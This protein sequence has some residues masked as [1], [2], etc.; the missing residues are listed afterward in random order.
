M[1][2]GLW[3]VFERTQH[4][5][6]EFVAWLKAAITVNQIPPRELVDD[7]IAMAEGVAAS[8]LPVVLPLRLFGVASWRYTQGIYRFDTTLRAELTATEIDLDT[9]SSVLDYLPEQTLWIEH[10]PADAQ[11]PMIGSF[12]TVVRN[13]TEVEQAES[14]LVVTSFRPSETST[15]VVPLGATIGEALRNTGD[16]TILRGDSVR[17]LQR[18]LSLLLYLTSVDPDLIGTVVF[19]ARKRLRCGRSAHGSARRFAPVAYSMTRRGSRIGVGRFARTCAKRTGIAFDGDRATSRHV[20]GRNGCRRYLS[21]SPTA[22]NCR[23]LSGG[24]TRDIA[25]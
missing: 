1:W 19:S 5:P 15:V 25:T 6:M 14:A 3:N 20:C 12:V 10:D 16:P 23:R 8:P 24:S 17:C 2:P 11:L 13:F 7:V 21:M 9:P 4:A 18:T 22:R